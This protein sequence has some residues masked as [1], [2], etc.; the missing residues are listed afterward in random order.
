MRPLPSFGDVLFRLCMN[1]DLA[2]R[3]YSRT[4]N[5]NS[6]FFIRLAL[7]PT[8]PFFDRSIYHLFR[9]VG[10]EEIRDSFCVL[11]DLLEPSSFSSLLSFKG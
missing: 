3:S 1:L 11:T 5:L 7:V 9:G 4:L 10:E 2:E 6:L 8:L